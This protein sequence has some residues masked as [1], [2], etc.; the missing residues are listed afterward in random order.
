[1]QLRVFGQRSEAQK[2]Q[3]GLADG[4]KPGFAVAVASVFF[5]LAEKT[6]ESW[7]FSEKMV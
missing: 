4:Q 2:L 5:F 1:M 7:D 6:D 3:T